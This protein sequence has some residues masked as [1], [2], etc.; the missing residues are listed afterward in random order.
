MENSFGIIGGMGPM[1]TELFYKMLIEKTDAPCDQDHMNTIILG[2]A[3]M[4]DRTEPSSPE[5]RNRS[6]MS[7]ICSFRTQKPLKAS[8][9]RP[10]GVTCNTAHYFIDKIS[11]KVGIPFIHMIK[12][13]AAKAAG[14]TN[15]G[16]VGILA[17]DGTIKTGLYQTALENEG[18]VPCV[19]DA[20]GQSY[21]MHEIYDCVK[22]GKPADMDM[23]KKIDDQLK[24]LGCQVALPGMHRTFSYKSR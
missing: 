16:K 12:E 3:T 10:I 17:T 1:A 19:L 24:E 15:G 14:L 23:W 11:D 4:P 8:A 7:A 9:A 22:A 6:A 13:T 2:H 20:E 21:V 18:A 5:I